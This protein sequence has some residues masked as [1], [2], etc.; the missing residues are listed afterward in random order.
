MP[1]VTVEIESVESYDGVAKAS[2]K[3]YTRYTVKAGGRKYVTFK[4]EVVEPAA[5]LVN[6]RATLVYTESQNGEYTNYGLEGV[7]AAPQE[8]VAA[9][10]TVSQGTLGAQSVSSG[11][12]VRTVYGASAAEQKKDVSIARA[13][14]FK[15]AVE[16]AAAGVI[17]IESPSSVL[18]IAAR[19]TPWLLNEAQYPANPFADL[20][21]ASSDE[22][23]G[24]GLVDF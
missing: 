15:G 14:A 3:A 24:V 5:L 6:Q 21:I 10:E 9:T 8:A 20:A 4:R 7:K 23:V 18:D 12:N 22:P 17:T 1:E 13:V 11:S 2:G 16:L 19:F